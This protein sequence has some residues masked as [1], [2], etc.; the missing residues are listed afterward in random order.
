MIK[1]FENDDRIPLSD[2][3]AGNTDKV[4]LIQFVAVFVSCV[5]FVYATAVYARKNGIDPID[6]RVFVLVGVVVTSVIVT[7]VVAAIAERI[8]HRTTKEEDRLISEAKPLEWKPVTEEMLAYLRKKRRYPII[9]V[10][11]FIAAVVGLIICL[12]YTEM[13][14]PVSLMP[15]A[16]LI[17]VATGSIE[18]GNTLKCTSA[19]TE[20][21]VAEVNRCFSVFGTKY[22]A[23]YLPSGRYV[24][25]VKHRG[26]NKI[27][28][29]SHKQNT[30]YISDKRFSDLA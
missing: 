30:R 8:C 28:F 27:V 23:V 14:F 6:S 19:D 13:I 29:L 25:R 1:Y 2:R 22:A 7:L 9:A 20:Y 5:L 10:L 18:C 17:S 4:F 24:Y 3:Y 12:F 15:Y 21:A 26:T 11:F 16:L